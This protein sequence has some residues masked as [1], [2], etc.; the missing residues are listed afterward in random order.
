MYTYTNIGDAPAEDTEE[1]RFGDPQSERGR[2][3]VSSVIAHIPGN[4]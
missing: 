1:D 4:C 2:S 3:G